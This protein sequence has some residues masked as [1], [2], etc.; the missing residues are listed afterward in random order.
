MTTTAPITIAP[1]AVKST[2]ARLLSTESI[3][4]VHDP[5]ISTAFFDLKARSLHLP[6]W[7]DVTNALYDMLVGHEV[8]HA[9]WTGA[10]D[11]RTGIETVQSRTGVSRETAAGTLNV[12]EDARIERMIKDK[13][14]GLRR[15]FHSG[16]GTLH[17][18]GFFG[19]LSRIPTLGFADRVNLHFKIG[20]H[21]GTAVPFSAAEAPIVA[22]VEAATTWSDV[23]DAAVALITHAQI[24]K[25][26]QAQSRSEDGDEAA[27]GSDTGDDAGTKSEGGER[28]TESEDQ[29]ATRLRNAASE[30][31]KWREYRYTLISGSMEEDI[32]KF[33]AI[34]RAERYLSHRLHLSF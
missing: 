20:L 1:S 3:A 9:L 12:V 33:R 31:E 24:T 7:K 22:A 28:G 10:D 32:E 15:D 4:V 17:A 16:Y 34:M 5:K 11:W 6:V 23:V 19:D 8:A 29:I 26:Q 13:F 21:L 14:P 25:Q 2:L 27:Q 18:R 30:M